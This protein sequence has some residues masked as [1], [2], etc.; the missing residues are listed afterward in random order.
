M[1]V[2]SL[3]LLPGPT[4]V[5]RVKT[6]AAVVS[7]CVVSAVM[8]LLG[9]QPAYAASP[10]PRLV[11]VSLPSYHYDEE[12]LA[13]WELRSGV[14]ASLLQTFVGWDYGASPVL[15]DFPTYRA[16]EFAK[17]GTELEITWDPVSVGRLTGQP[18]FSLGSIARGKHDAYVRRFAAAV[19][20]F[21]RPVRIRF[22][23]EMNGNFVPYSEGRNG[24]PIGSFVQ[25]W[26]HVH[27]IFKEAGAVNAKWV[28]SVNIIG[29]NSTSVK[30]LYPGD[31]YVDEL[32]VDGYSY[33]KA[34][35]MSPAQ[36]FGPTV[37]AVKALSRKPM[38]ITEVGVASVCRE[39]SSWISSF[40]TFLKSCGAMGFTWWERTDGALDY[41]VGSR[42]IGAFRS[43]VRSLS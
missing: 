30:G 29:S 24:N 27:D 20:V 8:L 13:N 23:H 32:G 6:M 9:V 40:F 34:G 43:G 18:D 3:N 38:R 16:Q 36:V 11:G 17:M 42:E 28:W 15:S 41:K 35:C 14:R 39:R 4:E 19:R 7:A 1:C 5:Q 10:S 12:A 26:R 37:Q 21:G 31:A 25:A 33:P 2:W 22:A